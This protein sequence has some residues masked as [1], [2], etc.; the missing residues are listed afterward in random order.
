MDLVLL[1]F[2]QA[3]IDTT[4]VGPVL[5]FASMRKNH[6]GCLYNHRA[7]G[8]VTMSLFSWRVVHL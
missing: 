3:H 2:S 4:L 6:T 5:S 1:L 8:W 7:I